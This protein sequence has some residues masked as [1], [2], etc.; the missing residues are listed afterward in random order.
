MAENNLQEILFN[1]ALKEEI[2]AKEAMNNPVCALEY[3]GAQQQRWLAIYQVIVSAGLEFIYT[4][5]K[6]GK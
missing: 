3:A 1:A 2:L 6:S 4:Q 5:W